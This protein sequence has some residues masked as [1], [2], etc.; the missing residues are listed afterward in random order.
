MWVCSSRQIWNWL[1]FVV[2]TEKPPLFNYD[3]AADPGFSIAY[4]MPPGFTGICAGGVDDGNACDPNNDTCAA[5]GKCSKKTV[6]TFNTAYK[7]HLDKLRAMDCSVESR[8]VLGGGTVMNYAAAVLFL[9]LGRMAG[10][11]DPT[12]RYFCW[13]SMAINVLGRKRLFRL[14][15][16]RRLW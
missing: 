2:G 6:D 4:W 1:D 16:N 8:L 10:R 12:W 3:L 5:P 13:I 9:M 14:F 7:S 15:R 11:T